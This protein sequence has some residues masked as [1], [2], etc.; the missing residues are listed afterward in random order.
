MKRIILASTSPRR[1]EI[2]TNVGIPYEI[3]TSDYEEDMTQDLTPIKLAEV[4]AAGKAES[5]AKDITDGIV[6][7]ADTFVVWDG[8]KIGKPKSEDEAR[9][10]LRSLSGTEHAVITGLCMI[11]TSNGNRHLSTTEIKIKFR[12]ITDEEIEWYIKTGEPMDKAGAYALQGKASIF[13][14]RIE[15]DYWALVG[16][17]IC[18]VSQVLKEW[19]ADFMTYTD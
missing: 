13:I 9:S 5:V 10:M 17:P 11:D 6:I 4:L 15:G 14:E 8:H 12:E 16:L 19:G 1:R 18:T 7:G 3:I 2:L